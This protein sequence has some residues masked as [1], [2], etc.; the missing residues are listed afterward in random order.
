MRSSFLRSESVRFSA[1][2]LFF[3]GPWIGFFIFDLYLCIALDFVMG[4]VSRQLSFEED[5][6]HLRA[7]N[8]VLVFGSTSWREVLL[9]M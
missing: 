8:V 7:L 9:P 4:F 3:R 5:C 6:L 2:T 1:Q